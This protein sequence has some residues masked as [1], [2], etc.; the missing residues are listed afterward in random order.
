MTN[1]SKAYWLT[2][3]LPLLL[4][5]SVTAIPDLYNAIQ[6]PDEFMMFMLITS[7][8]Q[9]F[10]FLIFNF[11]AFVLLYWLIYRLWSK[12]FYFGFLGCCTIGVALAMFHYLGH[13]VLMHL[14]AMKSPILW[15]EIAGILA[16]GLIYGLLLGVV[17]T[18][19]NRLN[20]KKTDR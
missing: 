5:I 15:Q 16:G 7:V 17:Y 11:F 10:N 12:Y 9:I 13:L 18:C 14:M 1:F 4:L 6:N 19:I 20:M 3:L 8:Q 2:F